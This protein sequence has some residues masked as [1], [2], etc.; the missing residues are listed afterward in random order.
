MGNDIESQQMAAFRDALESGYAGQQPRALQLLEKLL[1]EV[2]DDEHRGLI[3]LYQALFLGQIRRKGEARE[4]LREVAN[5]WGS[6]PE[7]QARIEFVDA[8]LDEADGNASRVLGKL[9]EILKD[10][11]SLWKTEDVRDLYEEIQFTRGRLLTTTG[12]CRLALPVLEESLTF[13]RPKSAELYANLGLC[14]FQT[15]KWDQAE[16]MLT[17]ALSNKLLP[18]YSSFAHYY[19]GRIFYLKG[20]VAKALKEFELALSEAQ[21]AGTSPKSIYD[22]LAKSSNYLGLSD[23]ASHY[24]RLAQSSD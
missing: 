11:Q 2:D 12:N 7:H 21:K 9:N 16:K 15:E 5:L 17:L 23:E 8:M 14:Y 19:L 18:D 4:R 1:H 22:A 20:A 10:Y 24:A 3:V 13:E 6:T